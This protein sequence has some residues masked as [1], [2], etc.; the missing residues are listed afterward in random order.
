VLPRDP[1]QLGDGFRNECRGLV[2]PAIPHGII[3]SRTP[4]PALGCAGPPAPCLSQKSYTQPRILLK[5]T[6]FESATTERNLQL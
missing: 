4:I 3:G 1:S 5:D 6:L 2:R